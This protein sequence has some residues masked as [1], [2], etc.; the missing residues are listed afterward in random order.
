MSVIVPLVVLGLLIFMHELGHF[1]AAK[2]GGFAVLELSFGMGPR[3]LRIRSGDTDYSL[4]LLPFGGFV[5]VASQVGDAPGDPVVSPERTYEGRPLPARLAFIA[6]GPAMNFVLALVLLIAV[7]WVIGIDQPVLDS[8]VLG[9]VVAGSPA[10]QA[11]LR[12]GDRV[13]AIDGQPV[14]DWASMVARVQD[15]LGRTVAIAYE[16][17]GIRYEAEVAPAPH[18]RDPSRGYL[19]VATGVRHTRLPLFAA[20][21]QSVV[22]VGRMLAVWFVGLAGIFAGG[23]AP[24]VSGPVGIIQMLGEA[25][26]FGLAN[27][28]YLAAMISA[29]FALINLFPIPALDGSRLVFLAL[30]KV[31]GRPVPPEQEGRIHMFGYALL[32]ALLVLLTYR[33]LIRLVGAGR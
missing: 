21:R 26:R 3:L 10:A 14:A 32:M 16:R 17:S 28:F 19:G 6:A 30:E 23:G 7:F 15:A 2:R 31:R 29:N 24:D 33:D 8:T 5:R 22:E 1:V 13:V 18:P 9:D 11:G 27:L 4:R 12:P 25:T 20:V